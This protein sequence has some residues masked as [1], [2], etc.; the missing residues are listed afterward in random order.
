MERKTLGRRIA[1][2]G[3]ASGTDAVHQGFDSLVVDV[4]Q[5]CPIQG[6]LLERMGVQAQLTQIHHA[7]QIHVVAVQHEVKGLSAALQK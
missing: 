7:N 2:L 4:A 3:Q 5:P 6:L 1:F